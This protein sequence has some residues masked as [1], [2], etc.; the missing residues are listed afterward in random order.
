MLRI[1]KVL[2]VTLSLNFKLKIEP[3]LPFLL[4]PNSRVLWMTCARHTTDIL[5]DQLSQLISISTQ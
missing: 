5:S 3:K 4:N 2:N 1:L